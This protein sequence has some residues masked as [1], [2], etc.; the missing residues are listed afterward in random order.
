MDVLGCA[1]LANG[2]AHSRGDGGWGGEQAIVEAGRD[3]SLED[4]PGQ[5][6][7]LGAGERIKKP[8]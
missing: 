6:S 7:H 3:I 4:G 5:H 8:S 1:K 2:V